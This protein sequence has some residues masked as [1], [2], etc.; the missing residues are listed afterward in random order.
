MD[1][2]DREG[3]EKIEGII[4]FPTRQNPPHPLVLGAKRTWPNGGM[5]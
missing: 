1:R 5:G 3:L 2:E 4:R